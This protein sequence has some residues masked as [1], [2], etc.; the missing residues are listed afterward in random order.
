[1]VKGGGCLAGVVC[2]W[3]WGGGCRWKCVNWTSCQLQ[4]TSSG[5][6]ATV[7]PASNLP[8]ALLCGE[9]GGLACCS[10]I[11]APIDLQCL[12][13]VSDSGQ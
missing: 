1:M 4:C 12:Q 13:V 8:A 2:V 5:A 7:G 6:F 9:A 10:S 11:P 3:W